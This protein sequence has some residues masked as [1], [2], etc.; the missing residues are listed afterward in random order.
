MTTQDDTV[1]NLDIH[2]C[3]SAVDITSL[4]SLLSTHLNFLCHVQFLESLTNIYPYLSLGR[5]ARKRVWSP[6]ASI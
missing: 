5:T 6:T 4:A 1:Q 3:K 2:A